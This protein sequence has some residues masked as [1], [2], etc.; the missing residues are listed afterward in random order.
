[1]GGRDVLVVLRGRERGG[2]RGREE[3][4]LLTST[5]GTTSR[6]VDFTV[7]ILLVCP[8]LY[9]YIYMHMYER[10]GPNEGRGV[11]G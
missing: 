3:V 9:I 2:E 8:V 5:H 4:F 11:G 7:I 10:C 6:C 1:M